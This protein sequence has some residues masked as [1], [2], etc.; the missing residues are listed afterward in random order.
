M[1]SSRAGE[2]ESRCQHYDVER[3]LYCGHANL[4]RGTTMPHLLFICSV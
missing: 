3:G 1:Q 4:W 2:T